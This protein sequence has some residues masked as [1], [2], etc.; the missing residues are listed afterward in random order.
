MKVIDY[1]Q[2]TNAI[3]QRKRELGWDTPEWT[4][5]LRNR[6]GARR[7][8]KRALLADIQARARAAGVRPLRAYF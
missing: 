6:G 5:R 1:Q 7:P 3:A 8:E 2:F 4:E